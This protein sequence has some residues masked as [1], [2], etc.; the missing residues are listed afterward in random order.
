M[1]QFGGAKPTKTPPWRQDCL[2]RK[3]DLTCYTHVNS[4]QACK[5]SLTCSSSMVCAADCQG[6]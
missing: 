4:G 3:H 1:F 2:Q 6:L 5:K